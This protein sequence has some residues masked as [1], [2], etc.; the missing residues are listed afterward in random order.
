IRDAFD[1]EL[2]LR[3]LFESPTV[4]G[5][6]ANLE[7]ALRSETTGAYSPP[8]QAA[9]RAGLPPLSFAQE[10]LWFLHQLEP[11]SGFYNVPVA[12]RLRGQ[13]DRT[14]LAR[15]FTEIIRRHEVLRTAFTQ[16]AGRPVQII[17]DPAPF[18]LP[19]T[20]IS[21]R[22]EEARDGE[23]RRLAEDLARL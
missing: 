16:A 3:A 23:A 21:D 20:D 8:L 1:V 13:L 10:R 22:P 9:R 5:L 15:T 11:Q 17:H 6:A 12:V 19:V 4:E 2:P 14:A 18:D 7:A